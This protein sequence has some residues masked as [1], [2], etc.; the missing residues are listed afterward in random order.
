MQPKNSN[1]RKTFKEKSDN[2]K[3]KEN[4]SRKDPLCSHLEEYGGRIFKDM[5]NV[6]DNYGKKH[7]N[8]NSLDYVVP[9]LFKDIVKML[10]RNAYC[11]LLAIIFG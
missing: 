8:K 3:Q 11:I 1:I 10:K 9:I 5:R 7:V 4:D 6:H 2:E